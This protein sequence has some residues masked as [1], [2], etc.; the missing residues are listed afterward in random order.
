[1]AA[2]VLSAALNMLHIRAGFLTNHLSDVVVPA[3]LYVVGRGLLPGVRPR[4]AWAADLLGRSPTHAA[5]ILFLASAA[6]EVSQIWWP[7]GI[8]SGRFDPLDLVS[9]AVG[10]AACWAAELRWGRV[11]GPSAINQ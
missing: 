4:P 8:F 3:W 2:F 10:L 9:F 7:H 5:I 6:T 1:M 11:Q